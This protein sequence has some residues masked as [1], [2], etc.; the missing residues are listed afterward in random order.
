MARIGVRLETGP[1]LTPQNLLELAK[2][3]ETRGYEVVCLPEGNGAEAMTQLAAFAA[4][5]QRVKLATGILPIFHRTPTLL[6]MAA[7]GLDA[8]SQG[9]F[10][11]GL[12]TGHPEAIINGHGISFRRPLTHMRETV[13]I[14]RRLLRGG[15]VTYEGRLF[16]LN[17]AG[18]AFTV[19]RP[20]LP[21]YLAA[22]GPQMVELAGEIADGV[23]LNWVSPTY[24]S[25]AL[26]HLH[27]GARKAGRDPSEIDVACYLRTAVGGDREQVRKALQLRI[28]FYFSMDFYR[29][30]FAQSGFESEVA[31]ISEAFDRGDMDGAAAAVSEE[32]QR[33]L[34]IVGS[35]EHCQEQVESLRSLGLNLPVIAPF[36][37]ADDAVGSFRAA[38]EAFSG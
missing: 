17:D 15:K 22:L 13:E 35:A 16:T 4:S 28:A 33:E 20:D 27:R 24:L 5:T 12:G 37:V 29:N 9:R 23:L 8:I 32:M 1:H 3:A 36:T 11:L 38:I 6:A 18:L 25:Q 14:V 10:I 2:L 30:F 34:G 26:E 31:T 21:I 19:V 7:G